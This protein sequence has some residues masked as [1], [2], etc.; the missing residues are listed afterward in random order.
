[1]LR[2]APLL[3][4]AALTLGTATAGNTSGLREV[5]AVRDA[6]MA[7]ALNDTSE[8][9]RLAYRPARLLVPEPERKLRRGVPG[10]M[11]GHNTHSLLTLRRR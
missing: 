8:Q 4:L 9:V 3:A 1:M 6:G 11:C 5:P 7:P 2:L 10:A